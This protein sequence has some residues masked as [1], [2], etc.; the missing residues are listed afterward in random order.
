MITIASSLCM[1]IDYQLLVQRVYYLHI[2]HAH[3]TI[4]LTSTYIYYLVLFA[5]LS[6]AMALHLGMLFPLH[7]FLL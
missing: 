1:T 5:T 4:R 7:V 2:M 6:F 3:R